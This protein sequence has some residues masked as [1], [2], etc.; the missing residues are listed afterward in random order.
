[1]LLNWDLISYILGAIIAVASALSAYFSGQNH[2]I[3][4]SGSTVRI[5][6]AV[7]PATQATAAMTAATAAMTAATPLQAK[8]IVIDGVTYTAKL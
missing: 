4:N 8:V 2:K 1:M 3:L 6:P 5:T 7:T